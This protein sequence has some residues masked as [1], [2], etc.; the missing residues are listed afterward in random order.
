MFHDREGRDMDE[1]AFASATML[2]GEIRDRRSR[3][4]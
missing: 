2:A 4:C 1:R 3:E